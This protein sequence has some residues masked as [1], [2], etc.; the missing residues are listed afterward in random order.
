MTDKQ[1]LGELLREALDDID[2]VGGRERHLLR[3]TIGAPTYDRL[4]S[5]P[6]TADLVDRW[7]SAT[8]KAKAPATKTLAVAIAKTAD[9]ADLT[10]RIEREL[11]DAFDERSESTE[12]N[13]TPRE[14]KNHAVNQ[15][16]NGQ[17]VSYE[18]PNGVN[19]ALLAKGND[20]SRYIKARQN[21]RH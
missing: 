16:R 5:K 13:P 14:A 12:R 19:L 2:E 4:I 11:N 7:L 18:K 15:R 3:E 6:R 9:R 10:G 21:S 17:R 20:V 1:D 8:G